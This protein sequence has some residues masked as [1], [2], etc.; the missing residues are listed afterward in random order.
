MLNKYMKLNNQGFA[1]LIISVVVIIILSLITV[2]FVLLMY[3]NQNNALK[4]ELNND[5]YYAAESGINDAIQAI[6]HGYSSSKTTCGPVSGNQYLNTNDINGPND[7][8][9]CLLIDETPPNLVYSDVQDSQPTVTVLSNN[10]SSEHI[11]QLQISWQPATSVVNRP[12]YSFAPSSWFPNCGSSA[13]TGPCFPSKPNWAGSSSPITSVLKV[14]LTPLHS[15]PLPT[16]TTNTLTAFL[17]PATTTPS[18]INYSPNTIG[19]KAG[20]VVSG[21]CSNYSSSPEA[22]N[23]TFNLS[24]A[25]ASNFLLEL[26]S[27]YNASQVTITGYSHGNQIL[28]RHSQVVIDSTGDYRGVLKRI[29]VRTSSYNDVGMPADDI[30]SANTLCKQLVAY[31][32][33]R[34]TGLPG[35]VRNGVCGL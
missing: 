26:N 14:A 29:Q 11:S 10:N 6:D 18:T 15:G 17:Y 28:F 16:N 13:V 1:P 32:T 4:L 9:S 35:D 33:N 8:Y 31:P 12:P 3:S 23:V 24:P 5:A 27:I 20:S 22:C 7:K 19:V 21:D 25:H 30:A 34:T 2:G